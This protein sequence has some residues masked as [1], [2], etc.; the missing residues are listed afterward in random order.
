MS[1]LVIVPRGWTPATV[2]REGRDAT[3]RRVKRTY[4]RHEDTGQ[5]N[6]YEHTHA[7]G[8]QDAKVQIPTVTAEFHPSD[9]GM[10]RQQFMDFLGVTVKQ[11]PPKK[12]RRQGG[13]V[14][15][16]EGISWH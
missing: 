1:D 8:H 14:I 4:K 6:G 3:G 12:P 5:V 2:V 13:L 10:S 7:D 16:G 9:F 11:F 15:P